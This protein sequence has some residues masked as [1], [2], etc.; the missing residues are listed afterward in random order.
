MGDQRIVMWVVDSDGGAV[1]GINEFAAD[2]KFVLYC[3]HE[4]SIPVP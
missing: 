4:K 3:V 1:F 2:E